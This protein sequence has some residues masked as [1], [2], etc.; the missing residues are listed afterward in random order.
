MLD[1]AFASS[2][3][4]VDCFTAVVAD[5]KAKVDRT[6]RFGTRSAPTVQQTSTALFGTAA[7]VRKAEKPRETWLPAELLNIMSDNVQ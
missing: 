6:T 3:F 7:G 5:A 1:M 4:G 2:Y